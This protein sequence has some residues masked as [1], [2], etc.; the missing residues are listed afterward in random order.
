MITKPMLAGKCSDVSALKYPVYA[1]PK[2]DGI[3]A[4]KIDGK[5]ISRNWKAIPN[6]YTRNTFE[7]L[8]PDG[9]DGELIL[10]G[11]RP[12]GASFSETSSAVMSE[13][14][15]PDVLYHAFDLVK[16]SLT[17]SYLDRMGNLAACT[18]SVLKH[19]RILL[20]ER[21]FN[22]E[23]LLAYEKK[24]L[25]DGYEGIMLRTA[26][27]PYK[28]GRS[29]EREGWLLKLKRFSD[30]EAIILGFEEKHSN[31]NEADEDAFGHTKR[32]QALA[33]MVPMNTMG[34][35]VVKDVKSGI[36][37]GLGTGFDDALR[38]KIWMNQSKY[39]GKIVKYKFQACGVKEK[40][41]FPVFLGWRS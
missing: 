39:L 28:C 6:S 32:S 36:T 3:R 40:P 1:T 9:L 10:K 17:E 19:V 23:E 37:F 2:L 30:S 12:C 8:L 22:E 34:K 21:I 15:D 24:C 14:G 29:T 4:L 33:G 31:Q 25:A 35:L 27:S 18:L 7:K 38:S 5:L 11:E 13:D 26:D 20:P 41:R 16:K